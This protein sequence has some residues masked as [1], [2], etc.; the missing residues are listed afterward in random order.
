M[1]LHPKLDKFA[2]PKRVRVQMDQVT[3][4]LTYTVLD[5]VQKQYE[6]AIDFVNGCCGNC[7]GLGPQQ[8]FQ[9]KMLA[10]LLEQRVGHPGLVEPEMKLLQRLVL[11]LAHRVELAHQVLARLAEKQNPDVA[12]LDDPLLD[13][14]IP[15]PVEGGRRK[16]T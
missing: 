7:G 4:Q 13:R 12:I 2:H 8:R 5:E 14:A 3:S 9:E 1:S 15:I 6:R 10:K 16:R 11:A